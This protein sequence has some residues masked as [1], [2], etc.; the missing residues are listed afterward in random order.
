M[1]RSRG[2][3][4]SRERRTRKKV[5]I[6]FLYALLRG[7]LWYT[8]VSVLCQHV[9]HLLKKI[10]LY[11]LMMSPSSSYNKCMDLCQ[12]VPQYSIPQ[13]KG[14]DWFLLLG[15][16]FWSSERGLKQVF[17][18]FQV[19]NLCISL[20]ISKKKMYHKVLYLKR[21]VEINFW[22]YDPNC[23]MNKGPKWDQKTRNIGFW[24]IVSG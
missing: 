14:W 9:W 21:K 12:I 3:S 13:K 16:Y 1:G 11:N 5:I 2:R 17:F 18:L 23:V 20:W 15:R 4:R 8:V 10:Y 24:T 7:I 22:D 19:K 6:V